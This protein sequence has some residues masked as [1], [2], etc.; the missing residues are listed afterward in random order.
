MWS[1]IDWNKIEERYAIAKSYV[2]LGEI[3][4]VKVSKLSLLAETD[5]GNL[6]KVK[7]KKITKE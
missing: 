4:P 5:K 7:R 3:I 6:Y 2:Y 1:V